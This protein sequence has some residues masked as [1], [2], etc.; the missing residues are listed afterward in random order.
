MTTFRSIVQSE[1][2]E[3]LVTSESLNGWPPSIL[4]RLEAGAG[5]LLQLDG[6]FP[7]NGV[8]LCRFPVSNT[9]FVGVFGGTEGGLLV[10][11]LEFL[12]DDRDRLSSSSE[13]PS[14]VRPRSGKSTS[15]SF[16]GEPFGLSRG[17][18]FVFSAMNAMSV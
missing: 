10:V 8:D 12:L 1:L 15:S 14:L 16:C 4:F 5:L 11:R 3:M 7:P 17:L 9:E 18:C 13:S 2:D 6:A